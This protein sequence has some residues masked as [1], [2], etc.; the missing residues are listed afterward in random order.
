MVIAALIVSKVVAKVC[1][2][3][4]GAGALYCACFLYEDEEGRLQ[5][6]IEALWIAI[7]DLQRRG[8]SFPLVTK[9]A[10]LINRA[11]DKVAGKGEGIVSQKLMGIS[12]CFS[13]AGLA[14]WT[15]FQ[16]Y[17]AIMHHPELPRSTQLIM[18]LPNAITLLVTLALPVIALK[19][20]SK[21][22]SIV[23]VIPIVA[24]LFR[25]KLPDYIFST[26]V[27][28]GL[29]FMS[30]YIGALL[31]IVVRWTMWLLERNANIIRI[32]CAITFHLI[33]VVVLVIL[34]IQH[35]H[36]SKVIIIPVDVNNPV[37]VMW[38]YSLSF[39]YTFAALNTATGL[40]AISFT[41][42]LIFMLL[43]RT[44]TPLVARI[45]YPIARFQVIR[46]RKVMAAIGIALIAVISPPLA[47][48]IKKTSEWFH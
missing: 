16:F 25:D 20:E 6:K 13:F 42:I 14:L 31:L 17:P 10:S 39:G 21:W 15:M 30:M 29:I 28:E 8:Q 11:M 43:H 3:L 4:I 2:G 40:F 37:G 24:Y 27:R 47:D 38:A 18:M 35:A 1:V 26:N 33:I 22:L 46:N 5:N 41:S 12:T 34:P 44:L 19:Y 32:T 7:D 9:I 45:L 23:T 36:A 48:L